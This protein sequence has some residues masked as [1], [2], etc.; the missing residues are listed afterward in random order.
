MN[1]VF[2]GQKDTDYIC[3]K[4]IFLLFTGTEIDIVSCNT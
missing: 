3:L 4:A 2:D 1:W